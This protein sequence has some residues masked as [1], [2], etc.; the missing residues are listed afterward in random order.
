MVTLHLFGTLELRRGST[1]LPAFESARAESLLGY[2]ALHREAP[3]PRERLAFLLWP[4]SNEG[5]ART[6]LR[7][8][9]HTLRR[10]L[11]HPERLIGVTPRMIHWRPTIPCWLDVEVFDRAIADE[12][13]S[14]AVEVYRGDL[15]ETC[16]DE[17]VIQPRDHLRQ[18]FLL[19]LGHLVRACEAAGDH[20]TAI[21]HATRLQREDPLS[22]E[23]YRIL[24]R[25]HHARGER[26]STLRVYHQCAAT[27]ERELGVAPSVKTRHAYE[28]VLAGLPEQTTPQEAIALRAS[29]LVGRSDEWELL[30]TRWRATENGA[31][32]FVL[33]TGEAG[34]GKTRLIDEFRAWCG[35]HGALV[36]EARS[37][38]AEGALA[39]GPLVAWLR[40]EPFASRLSR[41][42]QFSRT[43]LSALLPELRGGTPA[44]VDTAATAPETDQ[45]QRL[46]DALVDALASPVGPVLL[47][48]DD[49]QWSDRETLQF[50]HYLMRVERQGRVFVAAT[51]RTE[52]L[53]E[54]PLRELITG[55]HALERLTVVELRRLSATETAAVAEALAG[56]PLSS[57][58][59]E[60]LYAE[61]EG[62]PLF[63]VETFR[64]GWSG[65]DVVDTRMTPR[66]QAAIDERLA[67][68]SDAGREVMAAAAVVGREFTSALLERVSDA[69]EQTLLRGLDEVWRRGII[70]ERGVDAYDFSHDKIRE[71]AYQRL[72][73][74]RRRHGHLQAARALAALCADALGS[75]SAQLAGHYE[76]AG[77]VDEA[78]T[79]YV[80]AAEEAQR[81]HASHEAVRLLERAR[82]LLMKGRETPARQ[83]RELAVLS[84]L[85]APLVAVEGY[86]SARLTAIHERALEVARSLRVE[87]DAPLLWSLALAGLSNF[88]FDGARQF[89]ERLRASS[90]H[91]GD[92]VLLAQAEYV[93]GVAAFWQGA[94]EAAKEHFGRAVASV[95]P[96]H[97][98]THVVQYGHNPD[99]TC[100]M[101]LACTLCLLGEA[102]AAT[103]SRDAALAVAEEVGH[104]YSRD[105]TWVFAALLALEMR[106]HAGVRR[107]ASALAAG[108]T[109][110]SAVHIRASA[111]AFAG[112]VDVLDGRCDGGVARI[113]RVL[114]DPA[115]SEHAPGQ[116]AL[117]LR[118]LLE[119]CRVSRQART[120]LTAVDRALKTSRGL[121]LWTAEI[122]RLRAEF[123]A[124]LGAP[125]ADVRTEIE[126]ALRVARNQRATLF[127][128]RALADLSKR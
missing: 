44:T 61:T 13:W 86:R 64:A 9:L 16:H 90:A 4:D 101:R 26:A 119:A 48:L 73:P 11:R 67:R 69:D 104:P 99:S 46:F 116:D 91:A 3:Q 14:T 33:V 128:S 84:G 32:Q 18:Q 30:M 40:S 42:D 82:T 97:R 88:D 8:L 92:A 65:R 7:H 113:Q 79:W 117:A 34:I 93:L 123:L 1:A 29:P 125:R 111:E 66:L 122:H 52:D 126:H 39:Y 51:S 94:L 47:V 2:L 124:M 15:L 6:N 35:H 74:A 106:D 20:A 45:R 23:T 59:A 100:G 81:V 110:H 72:S 55:L 58:A 38:L 63:I 76:R 60:A 41:I 54:Q 83:R 70:R 103:R 22:E 118:V 37:Y 43:E 96:E 12:D 5:Q 75:V 57:A 24:M 127:E 115:M 85:P 28:A 89:G 109:S 50:L 121:E 53:D 56:L 120:G 78:V 17:W 105:L 71:A 62:S 31:A 102:A 68:L 112:H 19:A 25:L 27:L 95:R 36:A 98:R 49:L 107:Y 21:R 87:P 10:T 80:R 114:N 108:L 77:A